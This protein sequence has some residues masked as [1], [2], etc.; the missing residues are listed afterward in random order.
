MRHSHELLGSST[1]TAGC[2]T[3]KGVL[4]RVLARRV[5]PNGT[6]YSTLLLSLR[7]AKEHYNGYWANFKVRGDIISYSLLS[8]ISL[9]DVI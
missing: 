2:S 1:V 9:I 8:F 7:G 5:G 3:S 6:Y 4:E